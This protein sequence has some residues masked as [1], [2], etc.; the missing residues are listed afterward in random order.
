MTRDTAGTWGILADVD[1]DGVSEFV[2]A[3]PDGLIRCFDVEAP[4]SRCA[5]CPTGTPVAS[6]PNSEVDPCRWSIDL[7]RPV[8][9]MAAAD[10]DGDGR[11]ELVLGGSDG[12][13][14]ALAERSGQ[15]RILWK[16]PLGSRVGE[17][18]LADLDGDNHAEILVSDRGR[19]P[20]LSPR[21]RLGRQVRC[22]PRRRRL[23]HS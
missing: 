22:H 16:V 20:L 17:P 8:S 3:Q 9:R 15:A 11:Q 4:R 6:D 10:L 19:P 21:G 1:G 23:G 12:N 7:K 14:Y 18:V 2:H 13:L 5:T